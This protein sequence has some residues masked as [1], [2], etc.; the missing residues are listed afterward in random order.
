MV[1]ESVF[2]WPGIA[3]V[4]VSSITHGDVPMVMGTVL[5]GAAAT[6]TANLVVDHILRRL[7]LRLRD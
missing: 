3:Q 1:V 2:S 7:D 4:S 6:V 5:V